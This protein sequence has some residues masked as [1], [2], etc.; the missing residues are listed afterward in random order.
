M[1]CNLHASCTRRSVQEEV[2]CSTAGQYDRAMHRQ[3]PEIVGFGLQLNKSLLHTPEL[4]Q[5]DRCDVPGQIQ[6]HPADPLGHC[7]ELCIQTACSRCWVIAHAPRFGPPLLL[8][9]V[10]LMSSTSHKQKRIVWR[11]QDSHKAWREHAAPVATMSAASRTSS[12][13]GG[14]FSSS[15]ES[16]MS[17][18][19]WVCCG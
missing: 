12:S 17:S 1:S 4:L 6:Q 5:V 9:A 10:T 3:A 13:N 7:C 11:S 2:A 16:G 19:D 8:M 18:S 14:G 15:I